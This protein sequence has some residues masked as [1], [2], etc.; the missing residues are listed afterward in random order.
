MIEHPKNLTEQLLNLV[1]RVAVEIRAIYNK[2]KLAVFKVNGQVPDEEGN[3]Q[4]DEVTKASQ[5]GN[6]NVISST[7]VKKTD[8]IANASLADSAIKAT[9]DASGN[10][11]TTTY[12]TK[13][14]VTD[15]ASTNHA[16]TETTYGMGTGSSYGHIKLSDSVSSTSTASSG[17]AA[18]PKAVKS[19]YDLANTANSAAASASNTAKAAQSIAETAQQTANAALPKTNGTANNLTVTGV[20]TIQ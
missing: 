7:Y 8:K 13:T 1:E 17:I 12:A 9:Q 4:I 5:D 19:A 11:I 16:S 10:V 20:L 15:K 6:G 3:I 14:E 18:S 2:L